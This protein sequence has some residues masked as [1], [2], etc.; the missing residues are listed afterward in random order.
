MRTLT[1]VVRGFVAACCA[2]LGLNAGAAIGDAVSITNIGAGGYG[3]STFSSASETYSFTIPLS[4]TLSAD[5]WVRVDSIAL[6]MNSSS[7][8]AKLPKYVKVN[9]V[10]SQIAN[11]TGSQVTNVKFAN[12]ALKQTYSFARLLV[13]PGETYVFEFCSDAAGTKMGE[14][15]WYMVNS[16]DGAPVAQSATSAG[17]RITQEVTGKVVDVSERVFEGSIPSAEERAYFASD[18]WAG[19]VWLKNI[20]QNTGY[21][22]QYWELPTTYGNV[23]SVVKMTNV[24][25]YPGNATYPYTIELE[26]LDTTR[27]ALTFNAGSAS[28][29]SVLK[30]AGSGTL[31]NTYRHNHLIK[32]DPTSTF[33]GSIITGGKRFV[34]G[35]D[36]SATQD[37]IVID[38]NG[39]ATIGQDAVWTAP[40]GIVVNG[41]LK[42]TG[43]STTTAGHKAVFHTGALSG[44][45]TIDLSTTTSDTN[46]QLREIFKGA[47]HTF[48]G[49]ITTKVGTHLVFG[50]S[51]ANSTVMA[52][53]NSGFICV[54]GA[55]SAVLGDGATWNSTGVCLWDNSTLCANGGTLTGRSFIRNGVNLVLGTY[56]KPSL[57]TT[58]FEMNAAGDK[59]N[60]TLPE[61]DPTEA[62]TKLIGWT[63]LSKTTV[64]TFTCTCPTGYVLDARTDG[65]YLV[66]ATDQTTETTTAVS[67][68]TTL[69]IVHL[70]AGGVQKFT[71]TGGVQIRDLAIRAGGKLVVDPVKNPVYVTGGRPTLDVGAKIA[72]AEAYAGEMAGVFDL[73]TWDGSETIAIPDGLV[74]IEGAAFS[75]VTY[76][77]SGS[78]D[79]QARV[80]KTY[81]VLKLDLAPT[82]VKKTVTIMPLGDSITEGTNIVGFGNP[83]YRSFLLA[84]LAA[85]GY[86][87][88]STGFRSIKNMNAAG[89][90]MPEAWS[91][92]NGVSGQRLVSSS[93]RAGWRDALEAT[94][95]AS[96]IPDVITF[97]IGTNDS[98]TNVDR[99]YAEW[100]AV[101]K[102][103]IAARPSTKI[104]VGSIMNINGSTWQDGWNAKLKEAVEQNLPGFPA[105]QVFFADLNKANPRRDGEGRY[106]GTFYSEG[107]LHP[108]WIGHELN[109]ACWAEA[110]DR[111]LAAPACGTYIPNE[112]T[113]AVNN[114]GADYRAGFTHLATFAPTNMAIAKGTAPAYSF[115]D[116]AA[117]AKTLTKIAYYMELKNA[118]S[119][120]VRWVWADMDAFGETKTLAGMGVPTDYT[121]TGDAT[122]LH[123]DTNDGG[124][125]KIAPTVSGRTAYLQFTQGGLVSN[126][127]EEGAPT[128]YFTW[129]WADKVNDGGSYGAMNLYLRSPTPVDGGVADKV[130]AAQTLLAFSRYST[131]AQQIGIGNCAIHGAPIV[132]G[133]I[134]TP[135]NY[136]ETFQFER[137]NLA[138]Y[139]IASIEIWGVPEAAVPTYDEVSEST[140]I[141]AVVPGITTNQVAALEKAGVKVTDIAA[142]AK[143][144]GGYS[145]SETIG[146]TIDLVA[147]A[148]DC[149]PGEVAAAKENFTVTIQQ[150][151]GV[152]K[153][154]MKEGLTFGIEPK[155]KGS[156][157]VD[158]EYTENAA[159]AKFFKAVIEL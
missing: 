147:F 136:M 141:E 142:W 19:T 151:G 106:L 146:G 128:G 115:K 5:D 4:E 129:D 91:W 72:L 103:L 17:W 71:G 155:I 23:H 47:A 28:S 3:P 68:F 126:Q 77:T 62:E 1:R 121:F 64:E 6:G 83:N 79:S 61:G 148:L 159:D 100:V 32:I 90:F 15:R 56:A 45:G 98:G 84:M 12:N 131:A 82:A 112:T 39:V 52:F 7:D 57:T 120:N 76:T 139:K 54:E 99:L 40:A 123:I 119:G 37:Q 86:D 101:M 66:L 138:S 75:Q 117:A 92:H 93:T 43:N 95:D 74:D 152:W 24:T 81:T 14:M 96:E 118:C 25:C 104:V 156:T 69:S 30:L 109:A 53:S 73:L 144:K 158:G 127:A 42:F 97:K 59:I 157:T 149:A 111:A 46:H 89:V 36:T 51:T 150:V 65:L 27:L 29:T 137:L 35:T 113:G 10:L 153:A 21:T 70:G 80:T 140:P 58:K 9:G 85:K 60:L 78:L 31:K 2:V 87:V 33:D 63:E 8:A 110:I 55:T 38:E 22:E 154:T 122:N 67:N 18:S 34:I 50:T 49:D 116:E 130:L 108:N 114:V 105:N 145:G 26:D 125:E 20:A 16:E 88:K 41:A 13:R 48:T 135:V 132:Y 107:D 44:T 94:L 134:A 11:G 124:I 133:N 102:R 143:R